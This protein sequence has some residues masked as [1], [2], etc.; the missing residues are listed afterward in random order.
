M[1]VESV[2]YNNLSA[3]P[4]AI[5]EGKFATIGAFFGL[6]YLLASRIIWLKHIRMMEIRLEIDSRD[7]RAGY[8][9]ISKYQFTSRKNNV[10]PQRVA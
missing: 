7:T 4:K 3:R 2:P 10:P 9:S 6:Y 5:V 8:A 1:D